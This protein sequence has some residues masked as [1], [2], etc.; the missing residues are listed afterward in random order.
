[1][2]LNLEEHKWIQ[3]REV[4]MSFEIYMSVSEIISEFIHRNPSL[5]AL[6]ILLDHILIHLLTHI[7]Q[8]HLPLLE[9][10]N[11]RLIHICPPV[12]TFFIISIHCIYEHEVSTDHN[13][14]RIDLFK[15]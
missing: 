14:K 6:F 7:L 8:M 5:M 10:Y 12:I 13:V 9:S 15:V 11:K 3:F 2:I 1:M 4:K